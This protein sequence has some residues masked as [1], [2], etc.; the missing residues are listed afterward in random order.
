[1]TTILK[2]EIH[3]KGWGSE[4]WIYNSE[5]Y[6]GKFL[7]FQSNKKC[8]WHFHNIKDETF[9]LQNVQIIFM[10]TFCKTQTVNV[11]KSYPITKFKIYYS[12]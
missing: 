4:E 11:I 8:S 5:N 1:M 7:K 6:C 10:Y 2:P 9:H 12:P 3:H